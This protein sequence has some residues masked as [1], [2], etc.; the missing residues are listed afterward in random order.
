MTGEEII[1]LFSHILPINSD[2]IASSVK[3]GSSDYICGIVGL[4]DFL[5]CGKT[6]A[7]AIANS[8]KIDIAIH[9][10]GKKI[11]FHR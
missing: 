5:G 10:I 7:Q 11:F 6:K 9:R 1:E 2:Y 8:G 4:A 3:N